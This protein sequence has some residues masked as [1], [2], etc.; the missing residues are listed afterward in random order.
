MKFLPLLRLKKI[1]WKEATHTHN[2]SS[3]RPTFFPAS[4]AQF[5]AAIMT[6]LSAAAVMPGV[7]MASRS[8]LAMSL[9]LCLEVK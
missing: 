7:S 8:T 3:Q 1:S 4:L 5:C 6:V 9:P 2:K